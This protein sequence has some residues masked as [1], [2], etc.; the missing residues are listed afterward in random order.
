MN[1]PQH[2]R[3]VPKHEGRPYLQG[4]SGISA[5]ERI[6]LTLGLGED[7]S[8]STVQLNPAASSSSVYL[9]PPNEDPPLPA[10][11]AS[12]RTPP[13]LPPRRSNGNTPAPAPSPNQL[14]RIPSLH[15]S[16]PRPPV[17]VISPKFEQAFE[18]FGLGPVPQSVQNVLHFFDKHPGISG[19]KEWIVQVFEF[20]GCL[21]DPQ[22]LIAR[23]ERMQQW[24]SDETAGPYGRGWVNLWTVT[25]PK[26]RGGDEVDSATREA[27]VEDEN[28]END[29]AHAMDLSRLMGDGAQSE[30]DAKRTPRAFSPTPSIST[31][32]ASSTHPSLPTT[33]SSSL[34]TS[35]TLATS[36]TTQSQISGGDSDFKSAIEELQKEMSKEG[37][38]REDKSALKEKEKELKSEQKTREKEAKAARKDEERKVKEA[39]KQTKREEKERQKALEAAEKRM[40]DADKVDSPHHF[41][42]LPRKGTDQQWICV[43]VAGADS[44]VSAHCGLFFREENFEY[45]RMVRDVGNVVRSFWDG[46]GGTRHL[47]TPS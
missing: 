15:L 14:T 38:S 23:Y 17:R 28:R 19:V 44:E 36:E 35:T 9:T 32:D 1:D 43:P 27:R 12:A 37:I 42:V 13:P 25:V 29:L 26:R 45:D 33:M 24:G 21:L 22:G 10:P 6:N 39:A 16:S 34:S 11:A 30:D 46:D 40:R 5:R 3:M 2:V 31:V 8:L 7:S 20:G 18:T 41:I 4:S 47:K